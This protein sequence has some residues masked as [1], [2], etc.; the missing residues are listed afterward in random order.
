MPIPESDAIPYEANDLRGERLLVIAPHPDDEV[1]GCGGLIALHARDRRPVHVIIVT[2]GAQAG[3][4]ETREE[5]SRKALAIVGG[6][7]VEFLQYPDRQLA[8][9]VTELS[10]K[11]RTAIQTFQPDL[12]A[13]PSPV[14]IHPDHVSVARAFCEL[15]QNDPSL[16]ADRA[17]ARVAFYEVS[18]PIRP[19][20]LV[21][22]TSVADRKYE[23][24]AAH[25][26]QAAYRQ[27]SVYAEGLNAYRGMTLPPEVK[28]AEAYWVTPLPA[29]RTMPFS[30]LRDAIG[31]PKPLQVTSEPVPISVI[32]RTRNRPALLAEAV[33]SVRGTG[34]PAEIVVVNDGGEAPAVTGVSLISNAK[35]SGRSEAM[36]AGVRAAKNAYV[37]FLDDDDLYYPEH[38]ASL[39]EAA[40]TSPAS[41]AWYTDAVSAFVRG[42]A[43]HSRL[44][45]FAQGYDRDALLLDNYIPLITLLT[46]RDMFLDAGGFDPAFDLFEDWDFLIRLSA[47]GPFTR[48]PR[49]TCEIRHIDGGGSITMESPEGSSRFRAAKLQIWRKHAALI[50]NN[51]IANV[52]ERQKKLLHELG[53]SMV[54]VRGERDLLRTEIA[55][56]EREKTQLSGDVS[57]LHARSAHLDGA[58]TELRNALAAAD[59]DRYEKGVRLTDLQTAFD[60]V[61]GALH[62]AQGTNA[63]LRHEVAR[64]QT[65]LDMIYESRTW[66][67]HSIVEKMKGR[68]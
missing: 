11:L 41:V 12:I 26:S 10:G 13:V 56:L 18:A 67:L 1:I 40:R 7:A 46:K 2:D 45:I 43:T 61:S 53:S 42:G 51:V 17:V 58:N 37:S 20:A 64:L 54:E 3:D 8:S 60:D 59:A 19:N 66:K 31:A 34:Y 25:E 33:E 62:E 35:S 30:A 47:R 68:G 4:R 36:N 29:I 27:Y 23:A 44:R 39:S 16:F 28:F 50:D 5:E 49:I 9:H 55:R 15:V 32:I 6:A 22:I 24:I 65:L 21:D 52:L 48:V 57:G 63:A 38:L 14:E